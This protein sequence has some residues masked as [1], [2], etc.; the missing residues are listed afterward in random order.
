MRRNLILASMS[1]ALGLAAV[2]FITAGAQA[3]DQDFTL[4]N[5]TGYQIEQVFVSAS[6]SENW[7]KDVLGQNVLDADET[8]KITFPDNTTGCKFDLKVIYADK[9]TAS[10]KGLDLCSISRVNLFYN[11]A[12][13]TTRATT[14]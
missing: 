11:R 13:N 14:E 2:P 10:W 12:R 8:A 1:V 7:G 3:A 6:T 9:D 5:K 4:V